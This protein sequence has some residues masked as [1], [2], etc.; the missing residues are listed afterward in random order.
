MFSVDLTNV[1][2]FN[3][4]EAGNYNAH[5]E[6]AE[7]KESKAG[8]RYLNVMFKTDKGVTVF[9]MYNLF[10]DK[11]MVRNIAL[12]DL[13]KLLTASGFKDGG[14]KFTNESDLLESVLSCRCEIKV[15]VKLDS[16]FGDKNIIKGYSPIVDGKNEPAPF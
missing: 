11:E 9:S 8:S 13:K 2:E 6:R 4:L 3:L 16:Q 12:A 10:H 5:V 15:A 1:S 14:L 7:F